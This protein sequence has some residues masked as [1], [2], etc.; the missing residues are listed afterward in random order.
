MRK[1]TQAYFRKSAHMNSV[2]EVFL[3]I[4]EQDVDVNEF[5]SE[6]ILE[7]T[8]VIQAVIEDQG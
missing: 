6:N 2:Q 3:P 8:D 4:S 1:E 7:I 5:I